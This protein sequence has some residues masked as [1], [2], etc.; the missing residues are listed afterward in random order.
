MNQQ[1]DEDVTRTPLTLRRLLSREDT[2]VFSRLG[3]GQ[4]DPTPGGIIRVTNEKVFFS[5]NKLQLDYFN[6]IC[7][8][9]TGKT[10]SSISL[11]SCGR[12]SQQ[13]RFIIAG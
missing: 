2:D 11:Y 6:G 12:R 5:C 8:I 7:K 4:T 3:A 10:W 13:F 1:R 9:V